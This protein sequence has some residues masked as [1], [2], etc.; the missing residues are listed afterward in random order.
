MT[1]GTLTG[2]KREAGRWAGSV[3]SVPPGAG[4][5]GPPAGPRGDWGGVRGG[6]VA[7]PPLPTARL[8]RGGPSPRRGP[9]RRARAHAAGLV[10][11][12]AEA[13]PGLDQRPAEA[14]LAMA[15]RPAEAGRACA[16]GGACAGRP[17]GGRG[18]RSSILGHRGPA[19][20]GET[21]RIG[22]DGPGRACNVDQSYGAGGLVEALARRVYPRCVDPSSRKT[23]GPP[24]RHND[25]PWV[26]RCSVNS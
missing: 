21:G 8:T 18:S 12:P 9:Q 11:G 13:G 6:A 22:L 10:E 23:R 20:I 3:R 17:V 4:P 1:P 14:G 26:A 5:E 15:I 24:R 16:I 2:G 19:I 7:P 25:S